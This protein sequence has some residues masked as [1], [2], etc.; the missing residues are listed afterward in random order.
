MSAVLVLVAA[1]ALVDRDGRVLIA[2]RPQDKALGGLWEFRG[3][4][5][6]PGESP[7]AAAIRELR[8][9]LN[10][11]PCETCLDPFAFSSTPLAADRHLLMTLFVC[12]QWDGFVRLSEH[13]AVKWVGPEDLHHFAMP[14]ADRPLAAALRD[15]LSGR[16]V[17]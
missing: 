4:K 12:R 15:R 13:Q 2:Q 3:G 17:A 9:E 5:L 1:V 16:N 6:E 14:P 8:E 10:V 7:E 11:E